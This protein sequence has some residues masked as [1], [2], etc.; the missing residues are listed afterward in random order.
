[1]RLNLTSLT[2][3]SLLVCFRL[4]LKSQNVSTYDASGQTAIQLIV[5]FS[6]FVIWT[7][8]RFTLIHTCG[9]H[10]RHV[11]L[12]ICSV[13]NKW[14]IIGATGVCPLWPSITCFSSNDM[15]YSLTVLLKVLLPRAFCKCVVFLSRPLKSQNAQTSSASVTVTSQRRVI[16]FPSPKVM[17]CCV[18]VTFSTRRR[19]RKINHIRHRSQKV[20]GEKKGLCW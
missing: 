19:K 11:R 12:V 9:D 2:S 8:S 17:L 15:L 18:V 1:M 4:P 16:V 14:S 10:E 3:Y 13:Y 20:W 6:P 7:M 5:M